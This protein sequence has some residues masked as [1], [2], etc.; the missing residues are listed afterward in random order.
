MSEDEDIHT[1]TEEDEQDEENNS[2]EDIVEE[3][4][5]KTQEEL[6][7]EFLKPP[8]N[9]I[10]FPVNYQ[11][12][13]KYLKYTNSNQQYETNLSNIN[14]ESVK[15]SN[16]LSTTVASLERD[17]S[18]V[19]VI[20]TKI[21]DLSPFF[22]K[23]IITTHLTK[24]DTIIQNIENRI[25]VILNNLA[26][27][28]TSIDKIKS[29]SNTYDITIER[30]TNIGVNYK[31][32][33]TIHY[34]NNTPDKQLILEQQYYNQIYI[35]AFKYALDFGDFET[36]INGTRLRSIE[37]RNEKFDLLPQGDSIFKDFKKNEYDIIY[38]K[39]TE[40]II[41]YT[42]STKLQ[43]IQMAYL[44]YNNYNSTKLQSIQMSYLD[45]NNYNVNNNNNK[46]PNFDEYYKTKHLSYPEYLDL[47]NNNIIIP[48]TTNAYKPPTTTLYNTIKTIEIISEKS[49]IYFSI[50]INYI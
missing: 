50:A 41:T 39:N 19:L 40:D 22:D 7:A 32:V 27:F 21:E 23:N 45:Y 14:A 10:E 38:F 49:G 6:D 48:T 8:K 4:P 35:T 47:V 11:K 12:Y 43:S 16:A 13:N 24:I 34:L 44:H 3:K 26:D 5:F 15:Y 36:Y 18:D 2:I 30:Y 1:D 29:I 31:Y 33:D 9:Y 28:T 17:L 25:L 42:T 20:K 46:N 37:Y